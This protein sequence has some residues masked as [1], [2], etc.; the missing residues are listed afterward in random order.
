MSK[1]ILIAFGDSYGAGAE[2]YEKGWTIGE[3]QKSFDDKNFVQ[4]LAKNYS[5]C[6]NFSQVGASISGYI[7]QL[8]QFNKIYSK[9]N[10]YTLLV[11][12]SQHNRDFLCSKEKGWINLYPRI[13]T[14]DSTF[15]SIE[16]LWYDTIKYPETAHYNWYK[17]IS[18]IQTYSE[19]RNINDFYIEQFNKSPVLDDLEFFIDRTKIYQNPIIKEIFFNDGNETDNTLDWQNFLKTNNYQSY[20]SPNFHPNE[21]GHKLIATKIQ[22][23]INKRKNND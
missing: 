9:E 16:K 1:N 6:Y 13:S 21:D 22:N 8:I 20:Y 7:N 17:T 23:I 10:K 14:T 19:K 15:E 5:E 4:L 12:L 18:Y 3:E 11:M 2:L